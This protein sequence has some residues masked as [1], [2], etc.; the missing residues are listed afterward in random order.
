MRITACQTRDAVGQP[1]IFDDIFVSDLKPLSAGFTMSEIWNMYIPLGMRMSLESLMEVSFF[2]GFAY[3]LIAIDKY[4]PETIVRAGRFS[5]I[6]AIQTPERDYRA[7]G[8]SIYMRV[9]AK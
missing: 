2:N 7:K 8:W 9:R 3:H 1:P 5:K 4:S 6:Q